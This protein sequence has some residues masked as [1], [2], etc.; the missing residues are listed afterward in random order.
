MIARVVID[1]EHITRLI[2]IAKE[3]LPLEAT[4]LLFGTID[5]DT[6]YIDG[7]NVLNNIANSSIIFMLDP[8]E[9]YN[10]YKEVRSLGKDIICIFHSHPS[11]A[12]PSS[13]DLRYMSIGEIPWLILSTIDYEFNLYVYH[14][15]LKK[16][17]I[18]IR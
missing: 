6:A 14:K 8:D 11:K 16:L 7:I 9:F 10:V 12:E 17:D 2:D 5:K 13:L 18:I 4:A 1:K 3:A 15:G